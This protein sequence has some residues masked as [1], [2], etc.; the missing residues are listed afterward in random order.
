MKWLITGAAGFLGSAVGEAAATAGHHV[1]GIDRLPEKP[2]SW[3]G[4]YLRHDLA[5]SAEV[6]EM[7]RAAAPDV[8]AHFAGTASVGDS[9][10]RPLADFEGSLA[11]WFRLLDA[12]RLSGL[13]PR[14][15]FAS[16][17]AVYGSPEL[18]PTPESALRR[19]ESPYG[20]H[21][22]MSEQAGEE[23][24]KCFGLSIVSLRFFSVFGPRQRRLLVWEIFEQLQL[25]A[26]TLR[27]KGTGDEQR[28]YL[29]AEEAA[30]AVTGLLTAAPFLPGTFEAMN[31]ASG[32]P[33]TV[34][35]VAEALRE[36]AGCPAGIV[37][38]GETLLG[39]PARWQA[40]VSAL[41]KWVPGWNPAPLSK[42]LAICAGAWK[43][44]SLVVV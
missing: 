20:F 4:E 16:S 37:F 10:A 22:V 42:S 28:D 19:P 1:I 14:I 5:S 2:A 3:P 31:I 34:R 15:A 32:T 35:E 13:R 29:S 33:S 27:L 44:E 24:A 21:K 12:V 6:A 43:A 30:N 40:D 39:N 8:I 11:V 18:L 23:F 26:T 38:G 7:I 25:G 41:R 17:A 9:F 36:C